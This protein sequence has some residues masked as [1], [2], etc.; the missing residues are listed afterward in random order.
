MRHVGTSFYDAWIRYDG[1]YDETDDLS[2]MEV[3]YNTIRKEENK[4]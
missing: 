2:D 4:R 1:L 3:D